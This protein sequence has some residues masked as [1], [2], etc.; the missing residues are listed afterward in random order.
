MKRVALVVAVFLGAAAWS[1]SGQDTPQK[2]DG[3]Y[4]VKAAEKDG[5]ALPADELK[6]IVE[7]VIRDGVFTMKKERPKDFDAKAKGTMKLVLQRKRDV[8]K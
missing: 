5:E 4:V 3:T 6:K 8:D 7:V 2:L 1:A